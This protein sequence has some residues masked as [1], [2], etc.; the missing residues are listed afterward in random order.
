MTIELYYWPTP[1]G[2]KTTTSLEEMGVDYIV[3]LINIGAGDQF[4]PDFL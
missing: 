2:W 1:E 3:N 4:A